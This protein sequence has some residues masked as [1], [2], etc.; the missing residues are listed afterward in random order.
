MLADEMTAFQ[1]ARM[2]R[3]SICAP[4]VVVP[5][6]VQP[7]SDDV[8]SLCMCSEEPH[9]GEVE[10]ARPRA[11]CAPP[12]SGR[13]AVDGVGKLLLSLARCAAGYSGHTAAVA[14]SLDRAASQ[15]PCTCHWFI[16]HIGAQTY[17]RVRS[18]RVQT[19]LITMLPDRSHIDLQACV[20]LL[21]AGPVQSCAEQSLQ[22]AH[23]ERMPSSI[24][25]ARLANCETLAQHSERISGGRNAAG[26]DGI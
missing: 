1:C 6:P 17:A 3:I 14:S 11:A 7:A 24:A 13:E 16:A 15:R 4:S 2:P 26:N 8:L 23:G 10:D 22:G 19:R 18:K 25:A 20:V 21:L 5:S 9:Q 12:D